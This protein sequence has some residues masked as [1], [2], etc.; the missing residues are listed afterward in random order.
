MEFSRDRGVSL[1]NMN[2]ASLVLNDS[3]PHGKRR[4]AAAAVN[5]HTM[6]NNAIFPTD[7]KPDVIHYTT[8]KHA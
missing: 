3:S 8:K 7:E 6:T 4:K 5:Y 2:A 1:G